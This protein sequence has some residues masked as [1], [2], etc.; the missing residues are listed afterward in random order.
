MATN[1]KNQFLNSKVCL[2]RTAKIGF[3]VLLIIAR[4]HVEPKLKQETLENF[5]Q[6]KNKLYKSESKSR[7]HL[8]PPSTI[9]QLE[10]PSFRCLNQHFSFRI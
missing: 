7:T 1:T 5:V 3:N 2:I 9:F 10:I 8:G 4:L 6:G